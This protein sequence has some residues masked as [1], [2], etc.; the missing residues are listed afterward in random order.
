MEYGQSVSR[1]YAEAVLI[2]PFLLLSKSRKHFVTVGY[3]DAEGKQQAL[4]FRVRKGRHPF[5][6]GG[7]EARTGGGSSIRTPTHERQERDEWFLLVLAGLGM[8]ASAAD[9]APST[10]A[11]EE[12]FVEAVAADSARV[13][14]PPDGRRYRGADA[15]YPV[16]QPG[17]QHAFRAHGE[18]RAGRCHVE[19]R[20]GRP[21]LHRGAH[22]VG[23]SECADEFG[24]GRTTNASSRGA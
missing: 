9:N 10:A 19:G 4:V 1:R 17:K 24:T 21:G 13:R 15:R 8:S 22:F 18:P 7:L 3:V 11:I 6:T 2:S 20:G 5:L 14:G 16:E 23:Q 12:R